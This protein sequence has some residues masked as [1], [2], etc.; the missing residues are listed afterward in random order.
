MLSAVMPLKDKLFRYAFHILGNQMAA[1][2]VVQ[3]VFVKVWK[4]SKHLETIEN[5]E[6]WCMT[7]TR[8]L[9]LDKKRKVKTYFEPVDEHVAI[10]DQSVTPYQQATLSDAMGFVRKAMDELPENQRH[11]IHLREIEGYSYKEIAEVTGLTIDRV[12]VYLHRGRMTLRERL[13]KIEL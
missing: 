13:S 11:V 9:A 3:E 7:V 1:E 4:K 8:N 12:K 10:A 6:A 5:K 2:D